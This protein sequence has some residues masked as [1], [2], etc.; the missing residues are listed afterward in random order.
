LAVAS[1]L[2]GITE[3]MVAFKR[4]PEAVAGLLDMLATTAIAWLRAQLDVLRAPA[5]ILLLDDIAGMLSPR[6]FE[7]FARPPL[8]RIFGA[9]GGLIRV[10]H[11]DTPCPHL[12]GPL[13]TL[14]FDV[15]N[16]S[17]TMDI[18]SV[19]AAM[20]GVALMGNV[21]PLDV[22]ARGTPEQVTAWAQECVR[23]T[24]GRGLILSAG[25]GMSP[26]TPVEAIDAL[27]RVASEAACEEAR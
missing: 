7:Q 14:G 12:V 10:F 21:P 9:F 20:P 25:G 5:G 15:F 8:E 3:L 18:G 11:N 6:L 26:G 23:K 2:L 17:H 27:V 1:W 22:L 19:Q 16:F 4:Q 24:R 13:S